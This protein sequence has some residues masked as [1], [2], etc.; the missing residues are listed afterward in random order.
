MGAIYVVSVVQTFQ[1]VDRGGI[2]QRDSGE[3]WIALITIAV[4]REN[5]FHPFNVTGMKGIHQGVPVDLS[6]LA[7]QFHR[8]FSPACE[9]GAVLCHTSRTADDSARTAAERIHAE[10]TVEM[11]L[12]PFKNAGES[13]H[14]SINMSFCSGDSHRLQLT[15]RQV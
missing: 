8:I 1:G 5:M 7:D 6:V 2:P 11:N 13:I 12:F 4:E 14:T 10:S 15:E 9:V 3:H